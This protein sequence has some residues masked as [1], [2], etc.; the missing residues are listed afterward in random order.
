MA[1]GLGHSMTTSVRRYHPERLGELDADI[2]VAWLDVLEARDRW[3]HSP[4]GETIAA[5]QTAVTAMDDL[6]EL[7]QELTR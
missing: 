1:T 2:A 5:E 3:A 4:N 7:R 6:L